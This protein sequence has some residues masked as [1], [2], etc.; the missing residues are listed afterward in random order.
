M[1]GL[2]AVAL[3]VTVAI[4]VN[5]FGKRLSGGASFANPAVTFARSRSEN[6]V[7]VAGKRTFCIEVN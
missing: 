3:W 1:V 6:R 4:V 5:M 7:D 2:Y